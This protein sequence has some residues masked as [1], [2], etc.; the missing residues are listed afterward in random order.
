MNDLVTIFLQ[1][2]QRHKFAPEFEGLKLE[3]QAEPFPRVFFTVNS[4][5]LVFS[6]DFT[7]SDITLTG[8]ITAWTQMLLTQG[9]DRAIKVEGDAGKLEKFQ[10]EFDRVLIEYQNEIPSVLEVL[11]SHLNAQ[12]HSEVQ[13]AYL[14]RDNFDRF[15]KSVIDLSMK[16][17]ALEQ[18]VNQSL[19]DK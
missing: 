12:I 6:K 19:E 8:S 4:G 9:K 14:T 7:Q 15:K 3:I 10:R 13:D 17:D 2:L 1:A 5:A 18:K 16:I 11:S